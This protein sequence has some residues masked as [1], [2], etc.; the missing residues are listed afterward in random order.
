MG[1]TL[2]NSFASKDLKS[3]VWP[4]PITERAFAGPT[5]SLQNSLS[6]GDVDGGPATLQS[7]GKNKRKTSD[8]L[9]QKA[10]TKARGRL[11]PA[12]VNVHF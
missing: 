1:L 11:F 12:P 5:P 10:K 6:L 4:I 3:E 2:K 9:S 8:A 7:G